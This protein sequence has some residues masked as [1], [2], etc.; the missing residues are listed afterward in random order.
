VI[1]V[2]INLLR[3]FLEIEKTRHFG[4]AAENL[5]LTQAAIS[6]RIKLLE[7]L[8]GTTLFERYRNNIQLTKQGTKLVPFANQM[9]E[10]WIRACQE[11]K[12]PH[13]HKDLTVAAPESV[14]DSKLA[15]L[16]R[17]LFK[18]NKDLKLAVESLTSNV[19]ARRLLD[20][21]IDIGFVYDQPK[22]DE[23]VY[24]KIFDISLSLYA[25]GEDV[26]LEHVNETNFV[27]IDLGIS[28]KAIQSNLMPNVPSPIFQ[29]SNWEMAIDYVCEFGGIALLPSSLA[30]R[31]KKLFALSDTPVIQREVFICYA[32]VI[33]QDPH[34]ANCIS[35]LLDFW[36]KNGS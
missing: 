30:K 8:L 25:N 31:K 13:N 36:K 32:K 4:K 35:E 20:R 14:W 16:P 26:T 21:T 29:A 27:S 11:V 28:F 2:D 7:D 15:S 12:V 34:K 33:L 19:I 1:N 3:T 6:A 22:M 24:T 18:S 9:V 10:L 23:L 5:Y 17:Q